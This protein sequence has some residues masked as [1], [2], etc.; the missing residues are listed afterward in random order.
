MRIVVRSLWQLRGPFQSQTY[1]LI[2]G[3]VVE[4][5]HHF[6][7]C[8]HIHTSAY[9]ATHPTEANFV[10]NPSFTITTIFSIDAAK[11]TNEN[12]KLVFR[13][14]EFVVLVTET[15]RAGPRI[16]NERRIANGELAEGDACQKHKGLS[17]PLDVVAGEVSAE[18]ILLCLDE[19]MVTDALI[20]N[21]LFGHL[22]AKELCYMRIVTIS[23]A[24]QMAPRTAS[25]SRKNDESDLC[26][27]NEL[28]FAK[29]HTISRYNV[30]KKPSYL[31]IFVT[32]I[33]SSQSTFTLLPTIWNMDELDPNWLML[34]NDIVT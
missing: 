21:C 19:F 6:E 28:G 31:L 4:T 8:Y 25:R 26:V 2:S 1:T 3:R 15:N 30:H 27:D 29:D 24:I 16:E 34:L 14:M 22:L 17:D 18:A 7:N 11:L 10:K 12:S 33:W 23:E 32:M 20:L 5:P 13:L 9:R